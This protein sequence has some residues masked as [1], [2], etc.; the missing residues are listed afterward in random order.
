MTQDLTNEELAQYDPPGKK[1]LKILRIKEIRR[2]QTIQLFTDLCVYVI[3]LAMAMIL[4]FQYRNP[5]SYKMINAL[6]RVFVDPIHNSTRVRLDQVSAYCFALSPYIKS[7]K[8]CNMK[9]GFF[10]VLIS[11]TT[12]SPAIIL[13][14][15]SRAKQLTYCNYLVIRYVLPILYLAHPSTRDSRL[16]I[17]QMNQAPT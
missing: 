3:L 2:R 5:D 11:Q 15:Y 14:L 16:E 12:W 10:K 7:N 17:G 13:L 4:S 8:F 1:M 6:R 9:V